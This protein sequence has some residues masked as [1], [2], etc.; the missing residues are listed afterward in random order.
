M[1]YLP[2]LNHYQVED[3]LR[4]RSEAEVI[5][6]DPNWGGGGKGRRLEEFIEEQQLDDIGREEHT[7]ESGNHK[8]RIGRVLMEGG[9]RPWF[10]KEGWE[11]GSDHT[12]V[13]AKV[14]GGWGK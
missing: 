6:G 13:A 10:F 11:C 9:G 2:Q 1:A 7:H 4:S 12:I 3:K 5:T 8:C 14:G